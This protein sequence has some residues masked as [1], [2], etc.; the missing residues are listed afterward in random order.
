MRVRATR[1][2]IL[3]VAHNSGIEVVAET[4]TEIDLRFKNV[5]AAFRF[6][7]GYAASGSEKW[8]IRLTEPIV[9]LTDQV[10]VS[11]EMEPEIVNGILASWSKGAATV[12]LWRRENGDYRIVRDAPGYGVADLDFPRDRYTA[13]DVSRVY[14]G[15]VRAWEALS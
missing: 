8:V 4:I 7:W 15:E 12:H 3:G 13:D 2:A 14:M 9:S 10:R 1:D 6:H 5:D 11:V